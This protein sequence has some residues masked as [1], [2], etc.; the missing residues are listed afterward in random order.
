VGAVA[1]L[2]RRVAVE[3]TDPVNDAAARVGTPPAINNT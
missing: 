2:R 1:A 3:R